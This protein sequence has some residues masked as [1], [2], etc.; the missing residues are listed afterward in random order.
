M[1]CQEE[2]VC[3]DWLGWA[4]RT[5]TYPKRMRC[6]KCGKRFL[7]FVRECHDPGCLHLYFPKHKVKKKIPKQKTRH[8]KS[9]RGRPC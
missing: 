1:W 3:I 2:D 8:E 6:E 7:T 5:K 4:G 9:V